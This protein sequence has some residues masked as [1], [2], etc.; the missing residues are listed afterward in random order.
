MEH[1]SCQPRSPA[2]T[3]NDETVTTNNQEPNIPQAWGRVDEMGTVY[4]RDGETEREVG[5]F[6]DGTPEEALAYFERK[7]TDLA[8]QVTL[9]EQR[10]KRGTP[11]AD[12]ASTVDA[13]QTTLATANAVG[14]LAALRTRLKALGGAVGELTEKQ[15]AEDKASLEKAIEE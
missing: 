3:W 10:I 15:I 6:P 11:A 14:D 9:L 13:L 5:Q 4:V 7:Y 8:G 1:P 12:I 2:S